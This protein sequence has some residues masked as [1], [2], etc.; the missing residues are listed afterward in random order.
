MTRML[1][2]LRARRDMA[3]P[4]VVCAWSRARKARHLR[5]IWK[6]LDHLSADEVA[7]FGD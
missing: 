4:T 2:V 1:T 7:Y 6:N 5:P 3:R